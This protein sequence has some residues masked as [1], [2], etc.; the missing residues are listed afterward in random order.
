MVR[1]GILSETLTATKGFIDLPVSK[2][3][4]LRQNVGLCER[5]RLNGDFDGGGGR[6]WLGCAAW[7][8]GQQWS[9]FWVASQVGGK[10]HQIKNRLQ[11]AAKKFAKVRR[12]I[13]V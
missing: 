5:V 11:T 2:F 4:R 7:K 13:C 12:A 6:G 9:V 8:A 1:G 10:F 3:R